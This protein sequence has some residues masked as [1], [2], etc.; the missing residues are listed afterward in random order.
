[1]INWN[2]LRWNQVWTALIYCSNIYMQELCK[3]NWN[4]SWLLVSGWIQI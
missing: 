2:G 3:A 1:M 4:I